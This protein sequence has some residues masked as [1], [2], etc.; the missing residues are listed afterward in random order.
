MFVN[1]SD[2]VKVATFKPLTN[3]FESIVTFPLANKESVI[4]VLPLTNKDESI[5][6]FNLSAFKLILYVIE[7]MSDFSKSEIS[8]VVASVPEVGNITLLAAVVVMV[9]SPM[10]L[11]IILLP[12]VIVFPLLFTPVPP[13]DPGNIEFIVIAESANFAFNAVKA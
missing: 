2:P 4:V 13:F 7:S 10:P 8:F 9:K 3:K 12:N 5:F 1:A 6:A 11:V